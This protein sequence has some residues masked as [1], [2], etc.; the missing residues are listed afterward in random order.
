MP[1]KL[2]L[3]LSKNFVSRARI[4]T[5]CLLF[6][7]QELGY[8]IVQLNCWHTIMLIRGRLSIRH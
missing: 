4:A 3:Q 8:E 2:F 5:L 1:P 7:Q 6:A